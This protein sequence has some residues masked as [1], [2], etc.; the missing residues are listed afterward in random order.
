MLPYPDPASP[1]LLDT[2]ANAGGLGAVLSQVKGGKKHVLEY[3]SAKLTKPERNYCV[4]RKE[5]LVVVRS[6]EHFHPYLYCAKFSVRT[7]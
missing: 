4:A 5:L 2:D 1:Y 6:L 7:D 3:Y